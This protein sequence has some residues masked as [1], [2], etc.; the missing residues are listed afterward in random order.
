MRLFILNCLQSGL[1]IAARLRREIPLAGVIGLSPERAGEVSGYVCGREW[2]AAA[3]LPY[4]EMESYALKSSA[5]RERLQALEIDVLLVLGWQRLVPP[6]LIESCRQGCFG[7]H[8]SAFG[9]SGG[10]GRSPQNWA[11]LLQQGEFSLSLFEIDPGIDSGPVVDTRSFP[12]TDRD[13]IRSSY[14]KVTCL[15]AEMILC[16]REEGRLR[17][18]VNPPQPEE[19][20]Y[21]PQ[22]TPEDGGIDWSRST[23][24]LDAFVRAQTRPYPGAFAESSAGRLTVWRARPLKMSL[25]RPVPPIPGRVEQV[26]SG[27]ELL[28]RT[29]DGWLL[30]DEW[31]T[32][33]GKAP[34]EEEV[35]GGVDWCGQME[36]IIARHRAKLPQAPL[37]PCIVEALSE[38]RPGREHAN[39]A[40]A[41]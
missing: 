15:A 26:F 8:G 10:R 19:G 17:R 39:A 35:L 3:G 34:A 12:L 1:D 13:D 2:C 40:P 36:Q 27:G 30:L 11:L 28:V 38:K 23:S 41:R 6:W 20:L 25:E 7:L 4:L 5:D 32:T 21:L 14:I 29:G 16:A 24:A 33:S 37:H 31:E 22:R 18:G 9:I